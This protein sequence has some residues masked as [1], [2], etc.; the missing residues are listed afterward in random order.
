MRKLKHI[1]TILLPVTIVIWVFIMY[2]VISVIFSDNDN[3]TITQNNKIKKD[4]V[5]ITSDT[6][7][8][9]L[10]YPDPFL[11]VNSYTKQGSPKKN[12]ASRRNAA[13]KKKNVVWP[14]VTYLGALQ[15]NSSGQYSANLSID[16]KSV[17][18]SKGSEKGG[19]KLIDVCYDSVL[20]SFQKDTK[21]V[22]LCN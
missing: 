22:K 17:I 15:N 13:S 3:I 8:L 11:S 21:S 14:K 16:G 10:N 9:L 1:R 19:V 4:K 7:R 2:K 5:E 12:S 20:L 18:L 6:I